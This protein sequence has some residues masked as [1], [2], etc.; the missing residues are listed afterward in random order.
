MDVF[1]TSDKDVEK[2]SKKDVEKTSNI[3]VITTFILAPQGTSFQRQTKTSKRRLLD[4]L[5]L[6][7]MNTFFIIFLNTMDY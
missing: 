1:S 6:S 3:D 2:T 5:L 7:G 4:V